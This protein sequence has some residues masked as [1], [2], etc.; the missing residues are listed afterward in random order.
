MNAAIVDRM[1]AEVSSH[2]AELCKYSTALGEFRT[3]VHERCCD[4]AYL[5]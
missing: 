5:V 1:S 2:V 4:P 3:Q